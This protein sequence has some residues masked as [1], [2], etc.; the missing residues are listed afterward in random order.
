G[1]FEH[2][3]RLVDNDRASCTLDRPDAQ[4]GVAWEATDDWTLLSNVAHG[5][6]LPT[7]G[8]LYGTSP[9]SL[10]EPEL[11]PEASVN[12]DVGV[13]GRWSTSAVRVWLDG[14]VF[15]RWASDLIRFRQTSM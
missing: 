5:L 11:R 6:R 12:V 4:L 9:V 2:V 15:Q 14:F 8:E 3:G 13:R 1:S 7:L 10:G